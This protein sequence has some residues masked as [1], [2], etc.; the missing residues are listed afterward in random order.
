MDNR[1]REAFAVVTAEDELL[2][3]TRRALFKKTRGYAAHPV[4]RAAVWAA[5]LASFLLFVGLSAGLF[6]MPVSAISIDVNPS[7][8]LSVNRFDRVVAVEGCNEDGKALLEGL[9]LQFMDY[10]Q[11]L[12]TLLADQR[13]QAYLERGES[14]SI[15]VA[16]D[17]QQR[18]CKMLAT[19]EHCT[20]GR[21]NNVHCHAGGRAES[22]AAHQ[23]GL[24]CGKYRVFLELQALDPTVTPEDVQNMSMREI[25]DRIAA[26]SGKEPNMAGSGQGHHGAGHGCGHGKQSG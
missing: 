13:M 25:R 9:D 26:L 17:D 19:V 23:A 5:A 3:K 15:F 18:S 1:L 16:C 21:Q 7:L 8:E 12:D 14:L 11:A 24:S 6:F 10:A 2:E 22:E 4:R 20:G